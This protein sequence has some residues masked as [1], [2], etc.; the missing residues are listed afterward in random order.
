M[1]I[2]LFLPFQREK[3]VVAIALFLPFRCI[4]QS[5]CCRC[6]FP[7]FSMRSSTLLLQRTLLLQSPF[8]YLFSALIKLGVAF[9][10]F[11]PFQC[12]VQPYCCSHPMSFLFNAR[13]L[14]LQSP[15][16]YPFDALFNL[17]IAGAL[18]LPFQC[19]VQPYCCREPCCC[20]RPFPTFSVH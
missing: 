18:F 8:S 13:T 11:L 2:A 3:L 5:G 20:N 1:A 10:L 7:T 6:P 9:A 14:L 17:V 12:V 16:S 4:V 15:F 19:V